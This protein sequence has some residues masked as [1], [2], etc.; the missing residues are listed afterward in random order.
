MQQTGSVPNAPQSSQGMST[1]NRWALALFLVGLVLAIYVRFVASPPTLWGLLP[2]VLYAVLVL[3]GI[4]V[5]LST[6][7]S[8]LAA[9]LLTGVAPKA[10]ADIM[11][12]SL[13]SFI[14]GVGLI[15]I[16]GAG[17][18]Q[19][20]K[21]TGA[22]D[23]LVRTI[24][25][26]VGLRTRTRVQVGV[27]LTST[28]LV[29][30]LGTLAG[31]NAILA[32]I[33]IPIVAAVGFTPPALAAMLHAGGA[34]GLFIGPFTPP[35]VTLT[36]TAKIG[37][38]SYLLSAGV[39][40]AIATW[41]TGFFMARWIQRHTEGSQAYEEADL[42]KEEHT[43]GPEA[44]RGTIAFSLTLLLMLA[45]GIYIKAGYS[46]A[47][48]VMVVTS[49]TTGLAA[50]LG[51]VR[52]LQAIYTGASRFIWLFL[53]FWLFNPVLTLVDQTKAYQALLDV[54]KPL[55]SMIG[56]YQFGL[57]AILVG[58]VGVAGAAVAQVVL[59]NQ[60]FGPIVQQLGLSPAAWVAV[61]LAS[62]QLD[63]FGPFPNADMIGQMGL[64][65]SR[66]LRRMLYNGWAILVVNLVLFTILLWLLV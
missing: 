14:A 61:L 36:G 5:V 52:I 25:Y 17:L 57:I 58:W 31:A 38:V 32:P 47:L 54:G 35:V 27:M 29:G 13:G 15:I 28:I 9:V 24:L 7:A 22:A 4:D 64:A 56:A 2:I 26:R 39:P 40:M 48:L 34:P 53:L 63:W 45:Y 30:A 6:L 3:F 66:D 16:M 33:V 49:F 46:Y 37:Y 1:S 21:E 11:A 41:G 20:A 12:Q 60:V 8:L 51:P 50:K 19:V 44:R 43:L 18:G 65:R 59:M 23:Y 42:I 55:L 10:L 62:S